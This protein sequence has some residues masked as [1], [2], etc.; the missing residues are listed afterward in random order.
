MSTLTTATRISHRSVS[1]DR[2]GAI[3]QAKAATSEHW[4]RPDTSQML[5]PDTQDLRGL[6]DSL[7]KEWSHDAPLTHADLIAL[8]IALELARPLCSR[9]TVLDLGCGDGFSTRLISKWAK[10]VIG[11][12]YSHAM[13]VAARRHKAEF[14]NVHYVQAD[15]VTAPSCLRLRNVDLCIAINAACCIESRDRLRALHRSIYTLLRPGGT[16]IIQIPHPL[17]GQLREPSEWLLDI[18]PM[19]SYFASGQ[20]IRRRLR[21]VSG[22]WLTVARHHFSIADHFNAITAA[23]L[24]VHQ[25]L[26]PAA[27]ESLLALYPTLARDA[28][29]PSAMILVARRPEHT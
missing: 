9:A 4:R 17:D 21:T 15:I 11:I 3:Y 26:E 6:Y 25:L 2:I 1:T 28:R 29:L 7:A 10:Q 18:D 14:H 16:A 12:D 13:L 23:G 24:A 27:T 20:V 8:P 5:S 22:T 19:E